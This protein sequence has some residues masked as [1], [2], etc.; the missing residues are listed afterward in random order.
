M[1]YPKIL[2]ATSQKRLTAVLTA[3]LCCGFS[4]SLGAQSADSSSGTRAESSKVDAAQEQDAGQLPHKAAVEPS[5]AA[6]ATPE[7]SPDAAKNP[8]VGDPQ[9]IIRVQDEPGE[10][11]Q[12]LNK[13]N[14]KKSRKKKDSTEDQNNTS[15]TSGG[16]SSGQEVGLQPVITGE[17][18]KAQMRISGSMCYS[19]LM[20]LKKKLKAIEG[21]AF[22]KI[23]QPVQGV[24]QSYSPDVSSWAD[25][26]IIYD[27]VKVP[28]PQLRAFIRS[29]GYVPYK[30][31]D[32][33]LDQPLESFKDEKMP[34]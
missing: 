3:V 26:T 5:A 20:T 34:F 21:I 17:L 11:E 12:R 4:H 15:T 6:P 28:V 33:I 23:S 10:R 1:P 13:K 16:E 24:Y 30:L 29:N 9:M 2:A 8:T 7:S 14:R 31:A 27:P 32:K 19:C 25:T 18:H 22:V